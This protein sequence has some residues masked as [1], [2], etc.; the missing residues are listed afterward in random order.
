M[1]LPQGRIVYSFFLHFPLCCLLSSLAAF[2]C[3]TCPWCIL[4][5]TESGAATASLAMTMAT[6]ARRGREH[7]VCGTM[8]NCML[9]RRPHPCSHGNKMES[10]LPDADVDA[11]ASMAAACC[12]VV[13]ANVALLMHLQLACGMPQTASQH[14]HAKPKQSKPQKPSRAQPKADAVSQLD[15]PS[16]KQNDHR[17][18]QP[19]GKQARSSLKISEGCRSRSRRDR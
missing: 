16:K 4:V 10:A 19:R 2:A 13:S 7:A 3:P 15:Q 14:S 12:P 1:Q 18:K 9:L 5:E 6:L 17:A 11:D 8:I